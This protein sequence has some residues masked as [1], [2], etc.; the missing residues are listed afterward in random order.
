[1]KYHFLVMYVVLGLV[2]GDTCVKENVKLR[3]KHLK[4]KKVAQDSEE[5]CFSLCERTR[6]CK[7]FVYFKASYADKRLRRRCV[8]YKKVAKRRD[9]VSNVVSAIINNCPSVPTTPPQLEEQLVTLTNYHHYDQLVEDMD[10]IVENYPKIAAKY[11]IGQSVEGRDLVVMRLTSDASSARP[12]LRPMVKFL[13]NMHGNEAVGREL[14]L[15]LIRYLTSNYGILPRVTSLLDTLDI[16]ILPSVNPDGF[17]KKSR[18]NSNYVDLNRGFP[19]IKKAEWSRESL[20]KGREPEVVA[21]INWIL[22]NPFVV[23]INFHDGAVVANYPWDDNVPNQDGH[24]YTEDHSVFLELSKTYSNNHKNMHT[25]RHCGDH[26]PGGITNGADWYVVRGGMQD[27]NYFMTNCLEITVELSCV[28]FPDKSRLQIEWENNKN[29]LLSYLETAKGGL[30]GLVTDRLGNAVA[31]ATVRVDGINKHVLTSARGE[32]WR[33]LTKGT[34]RLT[35]VSEDGSMQ[36]REEV[37]TVGEE[38]LGDQPVQLDFTLHP[39]IL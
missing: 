26:F 3:G 14:M 25:G 37:L 13:A 38:G 17:E 16:H 27:F 6:R 39:S 33:L 1:M 9:R 31:N 28:K 22:D 4:R 19:D 5:K 12:L 23:S 10:T 34:Y 21:T 2:V 8:M 32:Y 36:S 11:S 30:R 15:A 7:G 20:L 35:A 29:S 18:Y 24:S